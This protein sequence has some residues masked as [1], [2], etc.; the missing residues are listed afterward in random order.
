MQHRMAMLCGHRTDIAIR[1]GAD[2]DAALM[3]WLH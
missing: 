2:L 3:R 1:P